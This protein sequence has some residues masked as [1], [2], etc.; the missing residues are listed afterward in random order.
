MKNSYKN[1]LLSSL[2]LMGSQQCLAL[3]FLQAYEMAEQSDPDIQAARY[4]YESALDA[5]PQAR[6]ALLPNVSLD[7]YAQR[8]NQD[9]NNPST[10]TITRDYDTSGYSL[11]L[12]QK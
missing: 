4:E 6:A 10:T 1:L 9:T 2:L 11:S 5:K 3:D 12:V 8:V 7:V